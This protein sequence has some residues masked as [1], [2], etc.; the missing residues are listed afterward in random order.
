MHMH[1]R[2]FERKEEKLVAS[3]SKYGRAHP[4]T[5]LSSAAAE[6]SEGS[7]AG[8]ACEAKPNVQG[9]V[10]CNELL[11]VTLVSTGPFMKRV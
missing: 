1:P 9:R 11:G 8:L 5:R 6:R 2:F 7:L 3:F 4:L 10:R